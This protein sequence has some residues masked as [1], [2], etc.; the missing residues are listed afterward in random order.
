MEA[1]CLLA[2]EGM[3]GPAARL[4]EWTLIPAT[5]VDLVVTGVG[6]S[7]AAG[8][9]ARVLDPS[10]HS[11]VVSIGICGSLPDWEVGLGEVVAATACVFADEGV[12][13]RQGFTDCAAMG[14]PPGEFEGMAVPVTPTWVEAMARAGARKVR[15]A[16]VSTCSGTDEAAREVAA[17]TGARAE[18]MEGAAAA[19]AAW[20]LGVGCGELRAVSNTTG[21]RAFQRWDVAAARLALAALLRRLRG[22]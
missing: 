3:D 9:V 15:V 17:R 5:T 4:P 19:L 14:F 1:E 18:A 20:R 12:L 11:G 22:S 13:T 2:V 6:K 21:D 10:R 8:A 16:T 7:N